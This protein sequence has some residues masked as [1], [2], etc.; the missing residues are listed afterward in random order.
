M[1]GST[2]DIFEYRPRTILNL[3]RGSGL[4]YLACIWVEIDHYASVI[5][6]YWL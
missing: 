4:D 3:P 2:T 1:T 5:G 6:E